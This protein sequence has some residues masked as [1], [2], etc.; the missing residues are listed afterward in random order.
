M[1]VS[2]DVV[3]VLFVVQRECDFWCTLHV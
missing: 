2:L 3:S 1:G